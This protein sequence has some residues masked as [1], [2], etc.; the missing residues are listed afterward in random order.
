MRLPIYLDYAATTP[1]DER[2][3]NKMALY[4][5][6][7]NCFGNPAS[8]HAFGKAA[9]QAVEEA[10]AQVADL[11]QAEENEIIWTSGATEA[12][13]LA[14]KGATSLYQRKGKHIVTL[15][16]EHPAVLDCCQQLE[17]SGF[18]VT[19][20]APRRNG[21]LDLAEFQ[22]ALREDTLLVSVMHIN[23]EMGV[24]QDINAIAAMTAERGILFHVDAAQSAGKISLNVRQ[25]PVDLIS[26]SAHK[27]YG[28]KGMGALYVRRKP[29][30]RV[31]AQI[32]GGGQEQGMRSGTLATHQI[33][34]MGEAFAIA[35]QDMLAEYHKLSH[36]RE[37][38]W[39]GIHSLENIRVNGEFTSSFPGIINICVAGMTSAD[40]MHALPELA[41]SA[42]SACHARGTEPSYVLRALGL[43]NE[44]AASAI[45]ISFGRFT[46][47]EEV[48]FAVEC[49]RKLRR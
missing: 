46:T 18:V 40:I 42:G 30:V 37:Q 26:F 11:I 47:V 28:P 41:I 22:A 36:Y 14:L 19:Y 33:V 44:L 49:L 7:Q 31:A 20:L 4:L 6:K 25:T 35:K 34:G 21:L 24:I 43:E 17:K 8:V 9:K 10:R 23:N 1:V 27:I 2:V 13:N 45:R 15:K 5:T 16:T 29:R 39:Q 12:N 48:E 3:A 32:H 38:F